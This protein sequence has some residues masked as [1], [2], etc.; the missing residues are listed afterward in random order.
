VT[1]KASQDQ[2]DEQ[3]DVRRERVALAE[4]RELLAEVAAAAAAT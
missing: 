1:V 4:I 2:Q 3:A